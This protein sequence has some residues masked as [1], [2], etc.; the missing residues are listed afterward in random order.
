MDFYD[1]DLFDRALT[2]VT[3]HKLRDDRGLEDYPEEIR[4]TYEGNRK[5][6][7]RFLGYDPFENEP[8]EE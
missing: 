3:S 5:T 2:P 6:V 1:S 7:L 4:L 8:L